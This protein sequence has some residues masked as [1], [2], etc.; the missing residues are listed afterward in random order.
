MR[1]PPSSTTL[2]H[3]L[4]AWAWRPR[5][6]RTRSPTARPARSSTSRAKATTRSTS[7][8][9]RPCS[10]EVANAWQRTLEEHADRFAHAA[11]DPRPRHRRTSSASG[12]TW[13]SGWTTRRSTASSPRRSTSRRSGIGKSSGRSAS[14]RAAGTPTSPT[15]SWRS[16]ASSI[17]AADDQHRGIVGG[18]QQ[19]PAA[20]VDRHARRG[21]RTGRPARRC[22]ALNGGGTAS[23]RHRGPADR[24]APG[25]GHR[26]VRGHPHVPRRGLHGA[27]LD[28]AQQHSTAT[29]TCSRSTTGPR[30]SARTTWGRRRCSSSSIARSGRTRTRSPAATREHDADRPDEPRHLPARPR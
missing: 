29:T 25:D 27:E 14:E 20:A 26:L 22:A 17:T 12:T 6:S 5:R 1:F 18:S 15:R 23:P 4:D 11:G 8:T 7:T 28:A 9:C 19:L 30:S 2:F 16:C 10:G 13:W 24:T 21:W 3:Y